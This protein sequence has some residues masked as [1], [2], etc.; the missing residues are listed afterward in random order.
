MCLETNKTN[1]IQNSISTERLSCEWNRIDKICSVS[2]VEN[3]YCWNGINYTDI[4]HILTHQ[5]YLVNQNHYVVII[6]PTIFPF[7]TPRRVIIITITAM[8]INDAIYDQE[9]NCY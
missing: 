7:N 1:L 5:T 6:I 2:N 3:V 9:M 8:F 4:I